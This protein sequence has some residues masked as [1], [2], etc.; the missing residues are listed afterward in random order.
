MYSGEAILSAF[1]IVVAALCPATLEQAF[2]S[3][4]GNFRIVHTGNEDEVRIAVKI[5]HFSNMSTLYPNLEL[6]D[7][8]KEVSSLPSTSTVAQDTTSA[9]EVGYN[10]TA[11][12]SAASN[13]GKRS[14][15]AYPMGVPYHRFR[16]R[17]YESIFLKFCRKYLCQKVDNVSQIVL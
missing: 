3:E 2:S 12:S 17:Y 11:E 14:A 8:G 10:E 13:V 6:P 1:L 5:P 4:P 16:K 7:V 15:R 9:T